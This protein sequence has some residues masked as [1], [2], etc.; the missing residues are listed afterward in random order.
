MPTKKQTGIEELEEGRAGVRR[1]EPGGR[2][3]LDAR[4]RGRAPEGRLGREL[5]QEL[6]DDAMDRVRSGLLVG[7]LA[8]EVREQL[9]DGLIDE[10]L[11]G[12]RGEAQILGPGGVLG[13]LTRRLVER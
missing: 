2:A 6:V 8:D 13:D 1:S 11:A 4:A 3:E 5:R 12:R 9:S 7:E 10:L